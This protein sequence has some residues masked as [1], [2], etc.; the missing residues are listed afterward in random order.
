MPQG[1]ASDA[2]LKARVEGVTVLVHGIN[3][4]RATAVTR[5]TL[6]EFYELQSHEMQVYVQAKSVPLHHSIQH[7]IQNMGQLESRLA[8]G[9]AEARSEPHDPA[10]RRVA[11]IGFGITTTADERIAAMD[12]FMK[13]HF[14]DL[15]PIAI[16]LFP[17]K[18]GL[19][20]VNGFV[21]VC[22]PNQIRV[23]L[24]AVKS[25]SLQINGHPGVKIKGALTDIDRA[26]NWALTKAEEQI[27]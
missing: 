5:Q 19:P 22:A 15:R 25:R 6:T 4:M 1:D 9:N 17:G 11:F 26:R 10:R 8:N 16:N 21:E 27:K 13:E 2:V 24:E 20:S 7:I 3:E 23:I 18:S 14:A 12:R